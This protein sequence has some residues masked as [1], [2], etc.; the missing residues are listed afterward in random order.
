MLLLTV[1]LTFQQPGFNYY[2]FMLT[3]YKLGNTYYGFNDQTGQ[4]I[5]F[6]DIQTLK[7]YFPQG[8]D[9]KAKDLPLSPQDGVVLAANQNPGKAIDIKTL[10]VMAQPKEA[11]PFDPTKWGISNE[12]WA[13]LSPADKAFVESS[14]GI[15]KGQFDAGQ[16]NV[17]INQDLLNKALITAQNDPDIIAKYGDVAKTA[18]LDV[19][20]NLGQINSNWATASALEE[21]QLKKQK[22]DLA[23]TISEAGQTYSGF[24]KQA[25]ELLGA[26][27]AN[28]IQSSKSALQQ[29]LQT[30]GRGY[31]TTFGSKA[32]DQLSP[33]TVGGQSYNPLGG[34]SG[35]TERAKKA[36][37]EAKQANIYN[38]E[39]L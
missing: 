19:S 38:L 24:R 12:L 9:P 20:F 15:L 17:S 26:E 28:I 33:M 13:T 16:S 18:A 4:F 21:L 35:T 39:K 29:K 37:V 31:E 2:N 10:Q 34:I 5:A 11:V 6:P 14:A 7:K 1:R 23:N 22:N 36:D 25:E 8:I 3:Q 27:Q 32:L 30:L